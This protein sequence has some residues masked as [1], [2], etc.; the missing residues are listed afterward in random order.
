[1]IETMI[2]T[3]L[4]MLPLQ[5]LLAFGASASH[6]QSI[7][8]TGAN[9]FIP[10]GSLGPSYTADSEVLIGAGGVGSLLVD[11]G[12]FLAGPRNAID[13]GFQ[14]GTGT[15]TATNGA[16]VT[17]NNFMAGYRDSVGSNT[18]FEKGSQLNLNRSLYVSNG[19]T[20]GSNVLLITDQD[21]LIQMA[22]FFA[23]G[24]GSGSANGSATI[25]NNA[26]VI[27]DTYLE[28]A[29][30]TGSQA[31]LIVQSGAH[32]EVKDNVRLRLGRSTLQVLSGGNMH[33]K[34]L[35]IGTAMDASTSHTMEISGENSLVVM[36]DY[37]ALG[38]SN[39]TGGVGLLK[40]D[41]GGRLQTNEVR[42]N[43]GGA[44]TYTLSLMGNATRRGTLEAFQI[45]GTNSANYI[46]DLNG[47]VIRAR[48][49]QAD[50]ISGFGSVTLNTDGLYIDSN[51]F[52][53]GVQTDFGA[54]SGGITKLGT[55][56]LT[57]NGASSYSGGTFVN[58]GLLI[59]ASNSALGTGALNIGGAGN[60]AQ[61]RIDPTIALANA[62]NIQ[63]Q[64]TLYGS[65]Q[66]GS[67][68]VAQG[69]VISPGLT[70]TEIAT[71]T[72]NGDVDFRSGGLY[73]AVFA[74]DS[75][76][77]SDLLKVSGT[78][79]L[80][81][82]SL[83]HT[84]ATPDYEIGKLYKV[85]EAGTV[86][87]TFTNLIADHDL[88]DLKAFYD[89]PGVV[90]IGLVRNNVNIAD[91][92]LTPNQK[93][94]GGALDKVND[95]DRLDDY[96][97]TLPKGSVPAGLDFLSGEIHATVRSSALSWSNMSA[98]QSVDQFRHNLSYAQQACHAPVQPVPMAAPVDVNCSDNQRIPAW[99]QIIG[100]WRQIDS[101]GNAAKS[102]QDTVGFVLGADT[103]IAQ[104]GWRVG[105]S[106]GYGKTNLHVDDRRS[107]AKTDNYSLAAYV[108][109]SFPMN[110]AHINVIGGVSYTNHAFKTDRTIP[111][112]NQ[113]LTADYHGNTLQL[114]GEVGYAMPLMGT[115]GLEPFFGV[116]V[117]QQKSGS[118]QENGGF[119][120]VH[121]ESGTDTYT[122]T[123]LGLRA[124]S[125]FEVS[126]K[127]AVVQGMLG[128]KQVLGSNDVTRTMAFNVGSP[129]YTIAA[130]PLARSTAVV[131]L[132]GAVNLSPAATLEASVGGEFGNRVSDQFVQARLRW[133]F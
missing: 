37:V 24:A 114:F 2:K 61:V 80:T 45:L 5:L 105:G 19:A 120:G 122:T 115:I 76:Y 44:G 39:N 104:S 21:T 49:N 100:N 8:S 129:D 106:F 4:K 48:G 67:T 132:Q 78:A 75:S 97:L 89:V 10:I 58:Q 131:S 94:T 32:I 16:V 9:T 86:D 83:Y 117:S 111:R 51:G 36:D 27:V 87:G 35:I 79:F 64:G 118:F 108:G 126:G 92:G 71:L 52:E 62:V 46:L 85:V 121:A 70:D 54:S 109:K 33:A 127:P 38:A 98:Q 93:A 130:V 29:N 119:A 40:I 113:Q 28:L 66:V 57:L 101:D 72:V 47:G 81:G 95:K 82:G 11:G 34:N 91:L 31:S 110:D 112:I 125:N 1:M 74:T 102:K 30:A 88:L 69:G 25:Q 59:P 22:N 128:W 7:T 3:T 18:T 20:T 42:M 107:T 96:V 43:T 60:T 103:E 90:N 133:A 55:G 14:G 6:A 77:N 12:S 50:L 65:G 84:A 73:R 17:S 23:I 99:V 13:V 68:V 15:F 26:R 123:T 53:V 63:N 124:K 41:D 56:T 116:N